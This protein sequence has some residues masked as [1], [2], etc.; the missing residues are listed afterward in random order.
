[1]SDER[2]DQ[3]AADDLL[4]DAL[5]RG[6]PVPDDDPVV[7]ALGAWRAD[8]E[9]GL[10]PDAPLAAPDVAAV[11]RRRISVLTR[12]VLGAAAAA[13]VA[14]GLAVS[15]HQAQP[16]SPLWPVAKV[17]YPERTEVLAAERAIADARAAAAAGR[18]PDAER[19]LDEATAHVDRIDDAEVA[20]R[21]R[22]EIEAIRRTLS[23]PD[24]SADPAT[25]AP[26]PSP[27]A[28]Q[29]PSSP[30]PSAT[31]PP[32]PSAPSSPSP[33]QGGLLDPLLPILPIFP[34]RD[35]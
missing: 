6:A 9:D 14:V 12:M 10:S 4:L 5:G 1:M 8:I 13:V 16:G 2:L 3:I 27:S 31:P 17:V 34:T 28:P 30:A 25:P 24:V 18:T 23:S 7:A 32:T 20:G 26:R 19:L 22:T 21:L 33:S 35:G 29:G 11:H 15:T